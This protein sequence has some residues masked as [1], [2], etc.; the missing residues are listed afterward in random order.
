MLQCCRRLVFTH[1]SFMCGEYSQGLME[2]AVMNGGDGDYSDAWDRE[3]LARGVRGAQRGDA[4]AMDELLE[5]LAP[6]VGRICG[7]V[8]LQDGADAAQEALLALF[9]NIRQL[10][11]AAAL[12]G[13]VRSIALREAVRAAK[14]RRE[15]MVAE[16]ADQPTDNDSELAADIDD[17][18]RRLSPEHSAVL[19]L[20]LVEGLDEQ[21][22]SEGLLLPGGTGG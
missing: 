14:R 18:L 12:F 6:Y 9:R 22:V 19:T 20:R 17:V 7:P 11:N 2:V 10:K 13:W 21:E 4:L 3:R 16:L 15:M 1:A 8:A 5:I